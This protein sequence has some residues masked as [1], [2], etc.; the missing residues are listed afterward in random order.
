MRRASAWSAIPDVVLPNLRDHLGRFSE[1]GPDGLVVVARTVVSYG[2]AI[3][4]AVHQGTRDKQ[5]A[6]GI[7]DN[8]RAAKGTPQDIAG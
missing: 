3:P 8:V 7:R 4:P 1:A 5:I 2:D 6:D